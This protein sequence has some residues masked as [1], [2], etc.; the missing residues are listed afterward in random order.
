M[1]LIAIMQPTYLPWLG[2]FAMIDRAD[3]FVLLDNVQFA[4]R[5]WQSRNQ[6][7]TAN[8]PQWLS[9]PVFSGGKRDQLI[10]EVDIE[11]G[12]DF[13]HA[14]VR[15]LELNYRKTPFYG[16]YAERPAAELTA[17]RAKLCD[18]TSGL[19]RWLCGEFGIETPITSASSLAAEGSKADRLANICAELGAKAYLSAPGSQDYIEESDA[20]E[21]AGIAVHYHHYEHPSY[22][23]PYG[24]FLPFMSAV[25]LLFNCGPESLSIIRGGVKDA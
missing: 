22:P 24:D 6:I 20:F 17:E 21:Q 25:D 13:P 11:R 23:Q 14:H 3:R 9:V 16:R 4:R 7:K 10:R 1:S 18:L 2:Y 5:S 19:I 12:R 8:G 15:A